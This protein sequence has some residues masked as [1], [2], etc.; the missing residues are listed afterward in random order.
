MNQK[1]KIV[2]YLNKGNSLTTYS[3]CVKR[4]TTK[5]PTRI[6]E[7]EKEGIAIKRSKSKSE[8]IATHFVYE[9]GKN[10]KKVINDYLKVKK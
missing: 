4:I 3:A 8:K 9:L 2:E 1:Q 5:L 6:A 7:I 10:S